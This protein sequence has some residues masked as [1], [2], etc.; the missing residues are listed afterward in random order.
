MPDYLSSRNPGG[1]G[2]TFDDYGDLARK[3]V[4]RQGWEPYRWSLQ[5]PEPGKMAGCYVTGSIP[6]GVFRSG[7]RKGRP[8]YST[9]GATH[10]QTVFIPRDAVIEAAR[11]YEQTG[12]C[13]N[14]KGTGKVWAGWSRETGTKQRACPR[15]NGTT[16]PPALPAFTS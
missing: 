15:C 5:D 9:P 3:V 13:W 10:T 12:Q 11:R 7:P 1:I 14:C 8:R 16:H 2:T 6:D 4:G